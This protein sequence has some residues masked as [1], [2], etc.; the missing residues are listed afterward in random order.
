MS[1][2]FAITIGIE[3]FQWEGTYNDYL[4]QL[5]DHYWKCVLEVI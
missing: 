4:V 2:P 3:L 1:H 5:P